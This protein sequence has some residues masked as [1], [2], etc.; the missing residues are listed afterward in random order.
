LEKKAREKMQTKLTSA[1]SDYLVI[2]PARGI[3]E[4]RGE[5]HGGW[6]EDHGAVGGGKML[7]GW[8]ALEKVMSLLGFVCF[9]LLV[10]VVVWL[11]AAWREPE[12]EVVEERER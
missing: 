8:V 2:V 12:E 6:G 5:D 7:S 1:K 3:Q 9:P 10:V 4:G 11:L